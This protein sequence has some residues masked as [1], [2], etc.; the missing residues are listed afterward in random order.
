MPNFA[1]ESNT[2]NSSNSDTISHLHNNSCPSCVSISKD[3]NALDILDKSTLSFHFSDDSNAIL[4]KIA[5]NDFSIAGF[6]TNTLGETISLSTY[7]EN[8]CAS[9]FEII[10]IAYSDGILSEEE[11]IEG[12]CRIYENY[13]FENITCLNG[14]IAQLHEYCS[15]NDISANLIARIEKIIDTPSTR[16]ANNKLGTTSTRSLENTYETSN[17]TIQYDEEISLNDVIE[18]GIYLESIKETY[19]DV[20]GF[21]EPILESWMSGQIVQLITAGDPSGAT[22]PETSYGVAVST[23]ITIYGFSTLTDRH[24]EIIAHEYFHAIHGS[25]MWSDTNNWFNEAMANWGKIIVAQGS[26]SCDHRIREYLNSA[27]SLYNESTNGYGA[28]LFPLTIYDECGVEAIKSIWDVYGDQN[29]TSLTFEQLKEDVIDEALSEY[30]SSF[31]EMFLQ[32]SAYNFAPDDW[33]SNV[34]PGGYSSTQ[35]WTARITTTTTTAFDPSSLYTVSSSTSISPY[36]S[37]YHKFTPSI[38]NKYS[39]ITVNISFS[40][41]TANY[42]VCQGYSVD[43]YG[44]HD[45]WSLTKTGTNQYTVVSDLY[46]KDIA[47]LGVVVSN[48]SDT[49]I[50]YSITY[51]VECG[52]QAN[53]NNNAHT[54]AYTNNGNGLHTKACVWCE[55]SVTELHDCVYTPVDIYG[56][57]VTCMYCS[58]AA[59]DQTHSWD[60]SYDAEGNHYNYCMQCGYES[61]YIPMTAQMIAALSLEAQQALIQSIKTST[62]DF[63][64]YLDAER[65]IL[66]QDGVCYLFY[67]PADVVVSVYLQPIDL[68]T[69]QPVYPLPSVTE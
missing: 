26:I 24:K 20:M 49:A 36:V 69:T 23:F 43:S 68:A 15:R 66:Y 34:H 12:Y 35:S 18:T 6:V 14:I 30:G 55:Y 54:I 44:N 21:Q 57:D 4:E 52:T 25:Y 62:S 9:R 22:S 7:F 42:G 5:N 63:I 38:T 48:T 61:D 45:Y 41:S 10:D 3:N 60:D 37:N 19:I 1:D 2:P 51:R 16:F 67:V 58:Y 13:L 11:K 17:F 33:Y 56:H 64:L 28:V 47:W 53:Q 29:S 31:D 65:G 46:G 40:G 39:K 59:E 32:M 8:A 27:Q 50:S